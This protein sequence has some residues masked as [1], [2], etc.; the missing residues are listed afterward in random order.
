MACCDNLVGQCDG[1]RVVLRQHHKHPV[2][3]TDARRGRL[4]ST[5]RMFMDVVLN[6]GNVLTLWDGYVHS[7]FDW[8]HHAGTIGPLGGYDEKNRGTARDYVAWRQGTKGC[9]RN[10]SNPVYYLS[11][12]DMLRASERHHPVQGSGSEGNLRRLGP[13]SA[14]SKAIASPITRLDRPLG[15]STLAR[16]L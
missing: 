6:S 14:R 15:A 4:K 5:A 3:A 7:K 10:T 1:S 12:T 2:G 16:R 8:V 13:V 11:D 9:G